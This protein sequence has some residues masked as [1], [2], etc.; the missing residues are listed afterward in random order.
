[1]ICEP[2]PRAAL[3]DLLAL[4]RHSR[5]L[6]D[7][8]PAQ[9]VALARRAADLAE[10]LDAELLGT[11]EV[12]DLQARAW[13]ELGDACRAAGDLFAAEA[14][15]A[16]ATVVRREGTGDPLLRALLLEHRAAL[17]GERGRA[18][19]A[20]AF[21]ETARRTYEELRDQHLVGRVLVGKGTQLAAAGEPLRALQ[22]LREGLGKLDRE[23]DPQLALAAVHATARALADCRRLWEAHAL[24]L[25]HQA[26]HA[27]HAG[28]A[29]LRRRRALEERI[30]AGLGRQPS[31]A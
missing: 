17:L 20:L 22:L 28:P 21:L 4:F 2:S 5:A 10:A 19:E 25:Q 30:Q 9:S 24:L 3:P 12:A 8:D 13:M 23:R 26:L 18:S 31:S 11:D 27:Q 15:F 1:M 16:H 7:E 14:T 6:R 29:V